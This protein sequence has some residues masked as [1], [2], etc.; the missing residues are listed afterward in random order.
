MFSEYL[1]VCSTLYNNLV[2]I[3]TS[4]HLQKYLKLQTIP[5][6]EP[7]CTLLI[8]SKDSIIEVYK[9]RQGQPQSH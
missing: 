3:L 5:Y 4:V 6:P 2:M 1:N 8:L 9:T 7:W